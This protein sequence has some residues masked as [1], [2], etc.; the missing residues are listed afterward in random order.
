MPARNA[1]VAR[2]HAR[3]VRARVAILHYAGPPGIGGV[4]STISHQATCLS[5]RGF[6]VDIIAGS[7]S[8]HAKGI[9]TTVIRDMS[10]SADEVLA[11]KRELDRGNIPPEFNSLAVVLQQQ[12]ERSLMDADIILVHNICTLHKNLALTKALHSL[13]EARLAGKRW[14][15]WHHDPAWVAAQYERELHAGMPW[16]LLH[17]PW[18]GM[19]HVTV[20]EERRRQLAQLLNIKAE[21]IHVI[22]PGIDARQLLAFTPVVEELAGTLAAADALLLLPARITRRKNISRALEVL[23]ETRKIT[24]LDVHMLVT[25]PPGP[26][27]PSNQ[28]Y[29]NELLGLRR[30]LQLEASAHFLALQLPAPLNDDDVAALYRLCDLMFLPSLEEGF[31]MPVLEA[32]AAG[33]PV[34][35]SNLAPMVA[36]GGD[37]V[38]YFDP[39]QPPGVAAQLIA[40][41]IRDNPL[42]ARRRS[43]LRECGWQRIIDDKLIPLF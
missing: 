34:V 23:H 21:A 20:S 17:T 42:L 43:V 40:E 28:Q 5:Q 22:P 18:P 27:N 1:D 26:H 9:H 8:A 38:R 4:E 16:S 29:V 32:L 31:G 37:A 11:V 36:S 30:Q 6:D 3:P 13:A 2:D 39:R 14:I 33:K 35:C 19:T 25:G 24:G 10:S 12:L 15:G 7:G 41:C